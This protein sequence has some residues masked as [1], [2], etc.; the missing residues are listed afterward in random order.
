[1]VFSILVSNFLQEGTDFLFRNIALKFTNKKI[2]FGNIALKFP[3]KKIFL[4][5]FALNLVKKMVELGSFSCGSL[6]SSLVKCRLDTTV[7]FLFS[8]AID[9]IEEKPAGPFGY[10]GQISRLAMYL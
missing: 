1:M 3:N 5:A 8:I 7:G 9:K 4:T 2:L 6:H 10:I